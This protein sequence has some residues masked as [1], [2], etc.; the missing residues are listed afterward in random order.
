MNINLHTW[1]SDRELEFCPKHFIK[2]NAPLTDEAK[3]W[4]Y[5][6]LTGRFYIENLSLLSLFSEADELIH[7]EDPQEAVMFELRWS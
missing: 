3:F 5:E 1:F 6:N 7:F 4:V 2:C